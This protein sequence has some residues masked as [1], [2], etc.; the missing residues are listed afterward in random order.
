MKVNTKVIADTALNQLDNI[1]FYLSVYGVTDKV[2][3]H[4]LLAGVFD[5][6]QRYN[7]Q[8]ESAQVRINTARVR[9]ESGLESLKQM[10]PQNIQGLVSEQAEQVGQKAE[11]LAGQFVPAAQPIVAKANKLRA[12]YI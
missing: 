6:M 7:G 9:L 3:R 10:N 4:N 5:T 8:K 2:N 11:A 12:R 1:G